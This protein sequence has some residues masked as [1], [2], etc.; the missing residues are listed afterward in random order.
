M[1]CYSDGYVQYN[2]KHSQTSH[3]YSLEA[4]FQHLDVNSATRTMVMCDPRIFFSKN[5]SLLVILHLVSTVSSD[6][7]NDRNDEV[8]LFFLGLKGDPPFLVN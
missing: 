2:D 8:Q 1:A 7:K 5:P 6:L 4:R 3:F